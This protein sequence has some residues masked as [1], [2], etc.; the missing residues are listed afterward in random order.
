MVFLIVVLEVDSEKTPQNLL[1]RH[2]GDDRLPPFVELGLTPTPVERMTGLG[3]SVGA[4]VWVK[5]DDLTGMPYGGNK[6]RKLEFLL[7]EALGL[8]H[9]SVLSVGGVGSNHLIATAVYARKLGMSTSAVVFPQPITSKVRAGLQLLCDLGVRLYPAHARPLIP[10]AARRARQDDPGA[11]GIPPGGSSALGALGYVC[12]GLEIAAQIH[13][14]H[15]PEPDAVFLPLGTG[16]T[17]CG[18]VAGLRLAHVRSKVHGVRVVEALYM[19]EAVVRVLMYRLLRLLARMGADVD[20]MESV[21]MPLAIV[22]DQV[23]SGYGLPTKAATSAV[24]RALESDG[25]S[26]ETTYSGKAMASL[27]S[28]C[29][30]PLAGRKVLFID[31]FNSHPLAPISADLSARR[32]DPLLEDWLAAEPV[33]VDGD[34]RAP[35]P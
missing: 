32:L 17:M 23:G 6:V 11:Y 26:L 31:T 28:M 7:G 22:H 24:A 20:P 21:T 15:L 12:A 2:V 25:L 27:V 4:D 30:G 5:R 19:N 3:K 34:R 16:G 8:G 13:D 1:G 14:G 10:F 29:R 9:R 35:R 18:L 33:E